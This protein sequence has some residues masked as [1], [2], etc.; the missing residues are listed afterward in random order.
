MSYLHKKLIRDFI[1]MTLTT[2]ASSH[3]WMK[4]FINCICIDRTRL[5]LEHYAEGHGT[6]IGLLQRHIQTYCMPVL[7]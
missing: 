2:R 7:N 5:E 4:C 3:L 6:E 1:V